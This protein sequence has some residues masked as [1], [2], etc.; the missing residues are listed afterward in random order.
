MSVLH[1]A[2]VMDIG[3]LRLGL[4]REVEAGFVHRKRHEDGRE[5]YVYSQRCVYDRAW[6]EFSLLARGLILDDEAGVIATPFPKFFNVGENGTTIPDCPFEVFEKLDGS[7]VVLHYHD[8]QWKAATKGSFDSEQAKWAEK[9]LARYDLNYLNSGTTYLAEAIYPENRIVIRY[10]ESAL[11]MLA[12]YREDGSEL[13]YEEICDVC[14]CIGWRP[15]KRHAFDSFADLASHVATLPATSEGFVIRFENGLRR[16]LKGDE[17]R[18]IHAMIAR[19]TPLALW[20]AMAN[21]DDLEAMRRELPEEFWQDFDSIRGILAGQFAELYVRIKNTA[22]PLASK[23]DKEV[24]LSLGRID[25][26]V[27]PFIFPYRKSGGRMD[28]RYAQ[29]MF[30][31]IRP[32]GNALDGYE[33]SSSMNRVQEEI[34]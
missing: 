8:G 1:P 2:R 17:Y 26:D 11:V 27:R 3:T 31:A 25:T 15:A 7:L 21:G 9:W 20:E 19:C 24:G 13:S 10:T 23:S 29:P 32:T 18:R 22:E 30:R 28:G 33:P 34:G 6:N 16:K 4:K 14:E 12:A 5:L